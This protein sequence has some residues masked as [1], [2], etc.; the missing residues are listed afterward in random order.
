MNSD[1]EPSVASKPNWAFRLAVIMIAAGAAAV[2]YV[3]F[4]ASSKPT[5]TAGLQRFAVGEMARLVVLSDA[6]PMPSRALQD[7]VA[8]EVRLRP[9]EVTVLNLWATWCAPCMEEMPTLGAL[10]RQFGDRLRVVAVS[11]DSEAD[12][13]K[14]ERELARLTLGALPFLS[15]AS[16]GVLF[17]LRAPGM[18]LTVIYDRSGVEVA[19]L[20]GGADWAGEDAQRLLEHVVASQ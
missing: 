16:R 1:I 15:D 8:A 19:L 12:L 9:G 20:A 4:A 13:A 2:L 14:A 17:D 11:V 3:L 6:P 10:Q 7:A 18:P 5:I